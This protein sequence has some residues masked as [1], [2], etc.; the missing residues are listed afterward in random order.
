MRCAGKYRA[1][2]DMTGAQIYTR[3]LDFGGSFYLLET[4]RDYFHIY[5]P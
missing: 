5:C 3:A 4:I 1:R 2:E